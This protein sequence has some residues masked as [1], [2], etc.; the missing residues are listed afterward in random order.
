MI[1]VNGKSW[2]TT[3]L[4]VLAILGAVVGIYFKAKGTGLDEGSIMAAG[5]AILTGIGLLFSKDGDVT[6][7]PYTAEVKKVEPPKPTV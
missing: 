3:S 5:T 1:R 2:K 7:E 6:T 4:G